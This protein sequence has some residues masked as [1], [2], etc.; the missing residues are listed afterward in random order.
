YLLIFESIDTEVYSEDKEPGEVD[1]GNLIEQSNVNL[2]SQALRLVKDCPTRWN[3]K[4][5]LWKRLIKLKDA[6]IWLEANLN[7]SQN[8]DERKDG[9]KL[10]RCLPSEDEW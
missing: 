9:Q 5:R 2:A 8:L 3:S 6:I 4:Y 7:I 10:R 1:N